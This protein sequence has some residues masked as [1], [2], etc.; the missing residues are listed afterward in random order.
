MRHNLQ[1]LMRQSKIVAQ[2]LAPFDTG[3]LRYNSFR[4]FMTPDQNGFI[5]TSLFTVAFYGRLLDTYGAGRQKTHKGWW[6]VG[7][8]KAIG[9]FV[10]ASL[11]DRMS[12]FEQSNTLVSQFAK[13]DPSRRSRFYDSQ[14]GDD[15]AGFA[16]AAD[17]IKTF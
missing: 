3:N 4:A 12:T 14:I 15:E 11:N 5:I 6:S 13:D 1:Q 17:I 2:S 9:S 8:T 7:V 10:N 16:A